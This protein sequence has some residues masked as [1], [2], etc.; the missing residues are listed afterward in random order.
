MRWFLSARRL[1]V[2]TISKPYV[3][4]AYRDKLSA[5]QATGAFDIGLITPPA[6][7]SQVYEPDLTPP[8]Y[9]H[10]QLPILF[11]GK[12]HFHVYKGLEAAVRAFK[13][14]LLNVE[15]EHYSFVTAQ[16]FRVAAR[17]KVPAIFYTWQNIGKRYPP[18][19]SLIERRVFA[20]AA[21]AVVGN[22][23]A[24]TVLRNKGY[25]GP[26]VEI[27]QMG[28]DLARF[29]AEPG[30]RQ[31]ERATLGLAADAFWVAFIGRLVEE[32]GIQDLLAATVK[33]PSR[34]RILLLGD[35]PYASALDDR[36]KALGLQERV[37]R[38]AAVPSSDVPRYLKAVDALCLPSRTRPNWKEQFGR[39]L[40]EAM[41][42]G[43]VPIGSSSGEIPRVIGDAGLIFREGDVDGLSE[44]LRRLS[45]DAALTM[46]FRHHGVRRVRQHFSQAVVA[47]KFASL[48]A[49]VLQ[50]P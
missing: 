30:D 39:V 13:P 31:R 22:E 41:A 9:W 2:L 37:H 36:I 20:Q 24:A 45:Q 26:L 38:V 10:Q 32:K 43:A 47:Q 21:A 40:V 28:V 25:R 44:A 6:W 49:A 5:L 46:A 27:P 14:D 7:G 35:G 48:F 19:F 18:P 3:A 4:R 11:N 8:S 1:R 34:V 50:L 17:L 23:E 12:N 29:G 42:A 33:A 15:E 16:A